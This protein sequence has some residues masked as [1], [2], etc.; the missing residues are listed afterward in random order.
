MKGKKVMLEM[1]PSSQKTRK[2]AVIKQGEGDK[3]GTRKGTG[4]LWSKQ[5]EPERVG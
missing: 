3:F 5:R 4:C 2:W 1:G